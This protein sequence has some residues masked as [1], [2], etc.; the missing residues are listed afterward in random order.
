MA[1]TDRLVND[2]S[3]L[4]LGDHLFSERLG[5][6]HHGIYA[7]QGQIVHYSGLARGLQSGKVEVTNLTDFGGNQEVWLRP[8][9]NARFS[10]DVVAERARSRIGEDG[11]SV[12]GNN[13]QHFVRWCVFD[14]HESAQVDRGIVAAALGLLG[15]LTQLANGAVSLAGSVSGLGAAGIMSGMKALSFGLGGVVGGLVLTPVTFA[16]LMSIIMQ[17]FILRVQP[18]HAAAE[19]RSRRIGQVASYVA[20]VAT[21]VGGVALVAASGTV[22]GLGAAGI[23]SGLAA[24]GGVVGGGMAAGTVLVMAAPAVAAVGIGYGGYKIA[25]LFQK[26][27][28]KGHATPTGSPLLLIPENGL[29]GNVPSIL[30]LNS[31]HSPKS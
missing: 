18:E 8:H 25:Q 12:F 2:E 17:R 13:C 14:K 1:N 3:D 24:I 20:G 11:Y 22:G 4:N 26:P 6:T 30:S 21:A 29:Q 27:S 16:I 31:D 23:A 9:P 19:R 7:G 5:Y 15:L 10:G 28:E